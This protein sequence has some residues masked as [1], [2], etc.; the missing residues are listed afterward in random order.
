[1]SDADAIYKYLRD[2]KVIVRNRT[3]VHKCGECLRLTIGNDAENAL[4]IEKLTEYGN[5]RK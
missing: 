5:T 3:R 4:L 2:E 1:M